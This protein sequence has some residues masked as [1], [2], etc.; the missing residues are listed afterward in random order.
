MTTVVRTHHALGRRRGLTTLE[1]RFRFMDGGGAAAIA[2]I[3]LSAPLVGRDSIFGDR[4]GDEGAR[5]DT[6]RTLRKFSPAPRF[7]FDVDLAQQEEGLFLVRFSQPGRDVPYLQGDFVWWVADENG[8]AVLDE[9]INTER[10]LLL[11]GEPLSGPR[12]SLRRWL[13]FR[14]GHI[15]VMKNAMSNIALLLDRPTSG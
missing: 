12:P 9:H 10:A 13:F 11:V 7:Q 8:G 3:L 15:Q 1:Q 14:A 2:G 5:S 6:S 4:P